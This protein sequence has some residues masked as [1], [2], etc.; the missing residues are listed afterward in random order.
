[1]KSPSCKAHKYSSGCD[2][3]EVAA[4]ALLYAIIVRGL[5]LGGEGHEAL[6]LVDDAV[7]RLREGELADLFGERS[8]LRSVL[9]EGDGAGASALHVPA[10]GMRS[11]AERVESASAFFV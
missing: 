4:A 6:S 10:S 1:M 9:H 5:S 7:S 8:A 2:L 3:S 11:A